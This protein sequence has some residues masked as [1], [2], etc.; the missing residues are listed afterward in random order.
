MSGFRPPDESF[1]TEPE[2]D[3]AYSDD[4]AIE[5]IDAP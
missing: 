3:E 1:A 2:D 5:G 4:D